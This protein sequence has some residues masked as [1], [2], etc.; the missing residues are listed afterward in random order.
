[1]PDTFARQ[2][3]TDGFFTIP[4]YGGIGFTAALVA[5]EIVV[6]VYGVPSSA[7]PVMHRQRLAAARAQKMR[8]FVAVGE[9][10]IVIV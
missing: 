2:V 3:Q 6:R 5:A 10:T 4:Q 1:M 9:P 7:H 8:G